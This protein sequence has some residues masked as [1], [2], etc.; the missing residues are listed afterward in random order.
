M[1]RIFD[2]RPLSELTDAEL[3]KYAASAQ[4]RGMTK[5]VEAARA[6][7]TRRRF[8]KD[9]NAPAD[10]VADVARTFD[11]IF[12]ERGTRANYAERAV[13]D[14]GIVAALS[15]TIT[16]GVSDT[17]RFLAQRGMLDYAFESIVLRHPGCFSEAVLSMAMANLKAVAP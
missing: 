17:L 2:G 15:N 11:A 9:S 7:R 3:R 1:G 16:N 13:R 5:H 6:E 4:T 14:H 8:S 12:S 10:L